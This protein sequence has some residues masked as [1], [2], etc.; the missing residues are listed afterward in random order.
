M[1]DFE[2]MCV[3]CG[4][5]LKNSR[6]RLDWSKT[7]EGFHCPDCSEILKYE[8]RSPKDSPKPVILGSDKD[9]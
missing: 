1:N 8:A 6:D 2:N 9:L 4:E 5:E 7:K 3:V